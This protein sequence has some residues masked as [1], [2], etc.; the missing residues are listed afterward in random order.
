MRTSPL[1]NRPG[2]VAPRPPAA[3]KP[4]SR[5]I[6]MVITYYERRSTLVCLTANRRIKIDKAD[7]TS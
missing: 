6:S 4:R 7:F 2:A 5:R 1:L 3:P